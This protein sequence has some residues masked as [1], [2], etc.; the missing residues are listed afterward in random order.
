MHIVGR[1]PRFELVHSHTAELGENLRG[2]D[3]S[4]TSCKAIDTFQSSDLFLRICA[5]EAVHE[6]VC[7]NQVPGHT[8]AAPVVE[9][10]A[11]ESVTGR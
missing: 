7:V 9:F 11:V 4:V 8:S 2:Q 5:I 6:H 10:V 1:H 3:T